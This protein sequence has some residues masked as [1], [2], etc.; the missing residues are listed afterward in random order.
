MAVAFPPVFT[1]VALTLTEGI[2]LIKDAHCFTPF[3]QVLEWV[4]TPEMRGLLH[5]GQNT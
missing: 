4:C 1:F 5:S 3:E 2:V